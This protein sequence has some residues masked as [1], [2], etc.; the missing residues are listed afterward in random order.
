MGVLELFCASASVSRSLVVFG[1]MGLLD[2]WLRALSC[3]PQL[4]WD[5]VGAFTQV[6]GDTQ[7]VQTRPQLPAVPEIVEYHLK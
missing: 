6:E 5:I 7:R 4:R 1:G 3:A 2:G